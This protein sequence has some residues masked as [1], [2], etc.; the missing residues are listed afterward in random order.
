MAFF[1]DN[2]VNALVFSSGLQV[3]EPL[4]STKAPIACDA[5]RIA[6]NAVVDFKG[7]GFVSVGGD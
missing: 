4:K 2:G 7:M 1:G 3:C 6:G 5:A